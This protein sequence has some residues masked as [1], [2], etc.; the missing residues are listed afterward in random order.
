MHPGKSGLWLGMK[1]VAATFG[2]IY[3]QVQ[4]YMDE[5]E[6]FKVEYVV[7]TVS[8]LQCLKHYNV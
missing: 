3:V 5:W 1:S 6:N 7:S 4:K 8:F 2:M